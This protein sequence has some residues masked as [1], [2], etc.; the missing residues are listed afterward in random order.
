MILTGF[1]FC[2][3]IH[4]TE[5]KSDYLDLLGKESEERCREEIARAKARQ[6]GYRQA[7]E[8]LRTLMHRAISENQ[9]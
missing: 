2:L 6:E 9:G 3:N 7:C 4:K 1:L 5:V 8:E